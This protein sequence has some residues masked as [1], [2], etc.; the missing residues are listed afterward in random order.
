[1]EALNGVFIGENIEVVLQM[2]MR[3]SIEEI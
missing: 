2:D 3:L 1:M